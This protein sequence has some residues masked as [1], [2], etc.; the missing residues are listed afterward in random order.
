MTYRLK[1]RQ[2][3]IDYDVSGED[4]LAVPYS[5]GKMIQPTGVRVITSDH[6]RIQAVWVHGLLIGVKGQVTKQGAGTPLP[7]AEPADLDTEY[8]PVWLRELMLSVFAELAGTEMAG[9]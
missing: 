8:V 7:I 1:E 2:D 6:N 4:N 3:F 5:N 9:R